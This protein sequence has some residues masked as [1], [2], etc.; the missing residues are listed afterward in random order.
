ME[1]LATAGGAVPGNMIAMFILYLVLIILMIV[2]M[3]KVFVKAGEKGWLIFIPNHNVVVMIKI[4][5]KPIWWWFL[6]LIPILNIVIAIKLM[7]SFA[8]RFGKGTG[9]ALGL[10]FLPFIFYPILAF[11]NAKYQG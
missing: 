7:I 2:S 6:F 5:G 1:V 4:A 10:I 8:N 11:G 3:W 9:F